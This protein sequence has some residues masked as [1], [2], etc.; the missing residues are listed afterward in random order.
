MKKL[1]MASMTVL[2]FNVTAK[3]LSVEDEGLLWVAE[4]LKVIKE[5]TNK[6]EALQQQGSS[7]QFDYTALQIDLSKII[8]EI[9]AKVNKSQNPTYKYQPLEVERNGY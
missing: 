2:A 8:T 5:A 1:L 7:Q 3:P 4:E 6:I 9:E